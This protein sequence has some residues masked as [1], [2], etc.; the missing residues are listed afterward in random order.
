MQNLHDEKEA[1]AVIESACPDPMIR[2]V[3]LSI[4]GEAI[5]EV[6]VYG[7]DT[8]AL[9]VE[10]TMRLTVKHYYVCTLGETGVWLALDDRSDSS[11]NIYSPTRQQLQTWGW[12]QDQPG[13]PGAYP[14][15]K[16]ASLR[17]DFSINGSYAI[18]PKQHDGA[19]PHIRRL[20]FDFIYKAIYYGQPMD[21]RTP[22]LHSPGAVKYLRNSL[23]M[24]LPDPLY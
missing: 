4:F 3:A 17:T 16:D 5:R 19:W 9:R 6:N 24:N 10:E 1:Q 15:Y 7:R 11:Q 22:G 21:L 14:T 23:R 8:W 18:D 13:Q 2:Q 20:F 12:V